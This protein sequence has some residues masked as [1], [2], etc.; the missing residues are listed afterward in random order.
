MPVDQMRVLFAF[1]PSH[2]RYN[3]GLALLSAICKQR[4]IAVD[5]HLLGDRER[6]RTTLRETH[7]DHVCLSCTARADFGLALPFAVIAVESGVSVLWGGPWAVMMPGSLSRVCRGDGET[8]PDFLLSGDDTLFREKLTWLDLNILPLP[9]YELFV[10]IPF[11]RGY[12][13][14]ERKNQL[15]YFSSRGCPYECSFCLTRFQSPLVRVRTR[16]EEDLTELTEIYKPDIL[17]MGDALLPYWSRS[18]RESWGEFRYPFFAYIHAGISQ[19][20]LEWLIDRGLFA[21]SFGVESGDETFRNDILKKSLSD[22]K[23]WHT[24]ETLR[25]HKIHFVP[26]YM[27]GVPGET[28][29]QTAK[30]FKLKD[31]IGGYPVVWEYEE[32]T[33]VKG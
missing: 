9:D 10:G 26:F 15:P 5:L 14:I 21:C 18:W 32:L 16:V 22:E 27:H 30:T 19:D 8:L 7:Y 3:H 2:I 20:N 29:T 6:F 25:R 11:N 23:L 17:F 12:G 24:V 28:F 1:Y 33:I 13:I 31:M 4:G